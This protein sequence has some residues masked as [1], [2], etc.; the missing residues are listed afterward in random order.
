MNTPTKQRKLS[1]LEGKR[2]R[3]KKRLQKL[4][5]LPPPIPPPPKQPGTKRQR[6]YARK[7]LQCVKLDEDQWQ[8]WGGENTHIVKRV[9]GSFFCDCYC[10]AVGKRICTHVIKIHFDYGVK[11]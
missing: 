5:L 4:G 7:V 8:V 2:W 11:I 6:T 1:N 3:E 9:D 10:S